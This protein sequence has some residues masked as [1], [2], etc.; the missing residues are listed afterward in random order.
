MGKYRQNMGNLFIVFTPLQL[1]VAQ[2]IIR[3]ERLSDNVVV[4]GWRSLFN[5]AYD[6]MTMPELWTESIY[7]EEYGSWIGDRLSL[8]VMKKQRHNF[9][10]LHD[11]C[12]SHN[13]TT[14]YLGE[15]LNQTCRFTAL[16]F[17]HLGYKIVF[18]EEGTSHYIDR[19]YNLKTSFK[20]NV[21][22]KL[23]D[24]LY[25]RPFFGIDF[26]KWHCVPNRPYD[27][28]PMNRRFSM[29]P[30][31]HKPWDVRLMVEPMMSQ[32]LKEYI[33]SEMDDG[34]DTVKRVMLMTDPLRELMKKED[35]HIYFEVIKACL[36]EI[37]RNTILYLKF[38]PREIEESRKKIL[39][40]AEQSGLTYRI[41]SKKVN[42]CVEYYLQK[43]RFDK[44]YFFNAATF[45]YNGYA[46]PKTHFEK[47][48]PVVYKKAKDAGIDNL[49]YME[50]MLKK[51]EPICLG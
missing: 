9:R 51:I 24:L 31:H 4:Y 36:D 3:Q 27:D 7:I 12:I 38:H 13:V 47:L 21:K 33:A 19:P 15:V 30:Y 25:F 18:F 5:D 44:I 14:L 1:F 34:N 49:T 20:E 17:S 45:F 40:I 37:P 8:D 42:I 26:A 43:Y 28:L 23:L 29:I 32:K 16:Y 39:E 2:Q 46:F 11:F 48:L 50:N 41:L 22:Q 35:L 10:Y 6:M